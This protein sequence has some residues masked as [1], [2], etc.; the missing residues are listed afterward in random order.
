M[1]FNILGKYADFNCFD[2]TLCRQ[3][4]RYEKERKAAKREKRNGV[5]LANDISL[6]NKH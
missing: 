5:D 1:N 3:R 2:S 4:S 6:L